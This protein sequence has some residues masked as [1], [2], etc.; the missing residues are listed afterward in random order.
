MRTLHYFILL[1][2]IFQ[3]QMCNGQ[4]FKDFKWSNRILIL[5]N[6][7]NHSHEIDLAVQ[8]INNAKLGVQER[9][10]KV[11]ILRDGKLY[12]TEMELLALEPTNNLNEIQEGYILIGKDGG[13]KTN[14]PYPL[15]LKELFDLID[16]MP[17]R[18]SEMKS[19]N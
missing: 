19:R 18:K 7:Q 15:A 2:V 9:D 17:M 6:D 14:K 10:L 16:S 13:I 11:Y 8:D 12:T 1:F 3:L 5:T 4:T